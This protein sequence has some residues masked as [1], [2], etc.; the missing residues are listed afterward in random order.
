MQQGRVK[1]SVKL[2]LM[3]AWTLCTC[4]VLSIQDMIIHNYPCPNLLISQTGYD[5][6]QELTP[7][8]I[9]K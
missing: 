3:S 2:D 8:D 6:F 5:G 1:C 4:I 7:T 9:R